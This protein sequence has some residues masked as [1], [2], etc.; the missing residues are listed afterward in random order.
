MKPGS[1][2]AA[3]SG[4]TLLIGG[5]MHGGADPSADFSIQPVANAFNTTIAA[6]AVL[7]ANGTNGDGGHIVVW[8]NDHTTFAGHLTVAGTGGHGGFAEVS[9]H[10][11]LDFT[12][13]VDLAGSAGAGTLL[14]DP[15]NVIISNGANNTGGSFAGNTNNSVIKVADLEDALSK[16]NVEVSTGS[17]GYQAGDITVSDP[18]S[19][20]ANN[21]TLDAYH[22]I[23]VNA[24]LSASGN[25]GLTLITNDGGSGGSLLIN[26]GVTIAGAG[27][28]SISTNGGDYSFG[29]TASGFTGSLSFSGDP[30]IYTP[31]LTINGDAYTL[32][33]S[34]GAVQ[35]INNSA[36][37]L[38]DHYALATSLDAATD[39]TTPASW[40]PIGNGNALFT[41]SF[42]GL[43]HV[44][45]KLTIDEG[46]N[47]IVGLFGGLAYGTI[48]DVGLVGGSVRGLGHVG[49][50]AGYQFGGSIA[51]VYA[52]GAVSGQDFVGGLVGWQPGGSITNAYATGT[53]SGSSVYVGG[54]VGESEG[55]LTNVYATG[56]VSGG[57]GSG[58]GGLVGNL[59]GG[60]LTNAYATGAVSGDFNVGGLA[61]RV[62]YGGVTN[63]YATGAVSGNSNVGGLIGLL[64]QSTVA[65]S[66]WDTGTS[67]K[68]TYG[69]S[70]DPTCGGGATALT[71]S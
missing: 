51:N 23:S 68:Q 12:G 67:G 41:G 25:A 63:A 64:D 47:S 33:Y 1:T 37:T 30:S 29:L 10:R 57:S 40:V 70:S 19:W 35:G 8:S 31:S 13:T 66:Y 53:V 5:D 18:V 39:S 50:L 48:R 7:N 27:A 54:L 69:C 44:I 15:Y 65:G 17:D 52:T 11:L 24:A 62:H 49:D 21:L 6:G 26:A 20:S 45:S 16:G 55:T 60:I 42:E 28:V 36:T 14:L 46:L 56:S 4:G 22:S 38:Q 34:M 71:T 3:D 43:G 2:P 59:A 9:S 32:L 58:I 61:G